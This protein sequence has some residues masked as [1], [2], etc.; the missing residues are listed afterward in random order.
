M[1]VSPRRQNGGPNTV[2]SARLQQPMPISP[3]DAPAETALLASLRETLGNE[4]FD[5]ASA[6]GMAMDLEG[7]S[8]LALETLERSPSPSR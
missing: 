2:Y 4:G 8:A 1:A 5:A 6:E 3:V 7:A